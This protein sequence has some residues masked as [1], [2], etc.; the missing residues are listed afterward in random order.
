MVLCTTQCSHHI[1]LKGI[2][3]KE[4]YR[5]KT[6]GQSGKGRLF[7]V[8]IPVR[9]CLWVNYSYREKLALNNPDV[10]YAFKPE[11]FT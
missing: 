5:I 11:L 9:P 4:S 8:K 2:Q 10:T 7:K 1:F 6:P 3:K